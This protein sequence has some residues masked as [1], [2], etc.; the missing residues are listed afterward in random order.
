MIPDYDFTVGNT[1]TIAVA[2]YKNN[3]KQ[4]LKLSLAAHLWLLIPVYGWARY[5]AI[6]AWIS[7]LSLNQLLDR[8]DSL[9]KK[10]YFTIRSLFL[11]FVSALINIFIVLLSWFTVL[12]SFG[13]IAG[14]LEAVFDSTTISNFLEEVERQQGISYYIFALSI[15]LIFFII[16]IFVHSIFFVSDLCL[17]IEKPNKLFSLIFNS[18]I[19]TKNSRFKLLKIIFISFIA[20]LSLYFSVYILYTLLSSVFNQ[21]NL[22][23]SELFY[24]GI[25]VAYILTSILANAFLLPFWQSIKA[26]TFDR[27]TNLERKYSLR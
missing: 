24:Y 21:L 17:A 10:K 6:A 25:I 1:I 12:F 26:V 23:K 5:F 19:Q 22:Y 11:F 18:Y 20:S 9:E 16:S 8:E 15:I 3:L 2:I 14:L 13:L 27:L 7:K 4:F